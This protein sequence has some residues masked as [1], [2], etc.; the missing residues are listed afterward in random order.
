MRL[1]FLRPSNKFT[2]NWLKR[3]NIK[4]HIVD[5]I[6]TI[7]V[8]KEKKSR[9]DYMYDIDVCIDEE[10]SSGYYFGINE[11]NISSQACLYEDRERKLK[12][13]LAN[14]LHE[15]RH[16][17]QDRLLGIS[18]EE[19]DYTTKDVK[20]STSKY[21]NNKHEIDARDFEVKYMEKCYDS[22]I[23]LEKL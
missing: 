12:S 7:V 11:M 2:I 21:W 5:Q 23:A 6:L 19:L 15:F 17:M 10:Y 1:I 9:K 22:Y 20:N 18:A 16:W 4:L 3:N 8:S 14:L 13:F